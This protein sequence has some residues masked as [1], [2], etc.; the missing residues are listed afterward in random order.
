MSTRETESS[1]G[2]ELARA[3][4]M[5]I[6]AADSRRI[7][8]ASGRSLAIVEEGGASYVAFVSPA[9]QVLLTVRVDDDGPILSF[10]R[11]SLEVAAIDRIDLVSESL[12]I[13]AAE[14][15]TIE[16]GGDLRERVGGA[17]IR[18]SGG[19]ATTRA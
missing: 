11:A 13:A 8:L 5:A 17:V 3:A 4:S 1:P 12:S 6:P 7:E 2:L 15:A 19:A 9:G 10:P 14:D 18:Q 16:V